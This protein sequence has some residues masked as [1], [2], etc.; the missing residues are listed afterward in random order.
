MG[1]P[2]ESRELAKGKSSSSASADC[3]RERYAELSGPASIDPH[4]ATEDLALLDDRD[5]FNVDAS[6]PALA[7]HPDRRL[8]RA[9]RLAALDPDDGIPL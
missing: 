9:A 1:G 2:I 8:Q 4:P 7:G 5:D 3:G 6:P